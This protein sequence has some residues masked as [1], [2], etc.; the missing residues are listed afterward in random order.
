[1]GWHNWWSRFYNA[2]SVDFLQEEWG[3]T[4]VRAAM[5]VEPAGAY[6]ETPQLASD[7]V[8]KVVD[9][10]IQSGRYVIIDWHSHHIRTEEAR[11]FFAQMAGMDEK[12]Q[13][14]LGSM[15]CI[16]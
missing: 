4:L 6:I 16:R 10:P 13:Y 2:S 7:C 9:A 14:Q 11:A 5:G 1:Y 8:T 15:V 12:Q 3:C